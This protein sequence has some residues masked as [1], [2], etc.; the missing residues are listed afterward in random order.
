MRKRVHCDV[1]QLRQWIET[2]G[3]TMRSVAAQLGVHKSV[4]QRWCQIHGILSRFSGSYGGRNNPCWSGGRIVLAG[5]V[6][7]Y[8]PDHPTVQGKRKKYVQ[9][10]RL[11]MEEHLGRLLLP[12]EVIHHRNGNK[13]DNRLEN[14]ELFEN[15][16]R[17]VSREQK[18]RRLSPETK[19]RISE[20]HLLRHQQASDSARPNTAPGETSNTQTTDQKKE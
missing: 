7:L 8:C 11:V 2:E 16:S 18:G 14:L 9:E 17:H 1:Q 5:Y 12:G 4:V 3:R 20:S 6:F 19:R 15:H 13:Q 10:H